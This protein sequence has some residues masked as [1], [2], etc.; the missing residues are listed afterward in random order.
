M[1]YINKMRT[2]YILFFLLHFLFFANSCKERTPQEQFDKFEALYAKGQYSN[3]LDI[4]TNLI[5]SDSTSTLLYNACGLTNLKLKQ[6]QKA[7]GNFTQTLNIDND[8]ILALTKRG[9]AYALDK[10][11][12]EAINDLK[13]AIIL[14]GF[15][16]MPDSI[17]NYNTSKPEL[18]SDPLLF[19]IV[20][21]RGKAYYDIYELYLAYDDFSL[22]IEGSL[23]ASIDSKF[24]KIPECYYWRGHTF[25]RMH[26]TKRACV[27][28]QIAAESGISQAVHDMEEICQ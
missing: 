12:S 8:N 27:D 11:Y 14:K 10:N 26:E 16:P 13:K 18:Y 22:C 25:N 20:Y 2:I 23:N 28:L 21:L 3:A 1:L 19:D 6:Y 7:I 15:K 9:E 4:I 5:E 24:D 17:W